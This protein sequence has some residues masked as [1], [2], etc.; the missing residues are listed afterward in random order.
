[1]TYQYYSK[2]FTG[3]LFIFSLF[4]VALISSGNLSAQVHMTNL[5]T[6]SFEMSLEMTPTSDGNYVTVG[7]VIR[8]AVTHAAIGIDIYLNKVDGAGGLIWSR[9]IAQFGT[10]GMGH[11]FPLSVTE[12]V[13][14]AGNAT[15]FA[16]TGMLAAVG[17]QEPVFIVT[18]DNNGNP[19][20]YNSYGGNLNGGTGLGTMAGFGAQI[21]QNNQ[22]QL[23][24]CGSM[25]I[26]DYVGQ[27]PFILVVQPD[28]TLDFL[29]L[30]HDVRYL[31]NQFGFDVRSHFADIEVVLEG[32]SDQTGASVPE[33][34]V[35]VGTTAEMNNPFSEI[36]VMRTDLA[37]GPVS[38]GLYGPENGNS[39]GTAIETTSNGNL[40]VA[41]I[42]VTPPP[43]TGGP[44]SP[45]ST[46]VLKL[47]SAMLG[48]LDQDRYYGF[49][50]LGDIRE[51]ANGDFLLSGRGVF[52]ADGAILRIKNDGTLVFGNGYG[53]PNVELFWDTHEMPSGD[54]Y[55]SGVTTTWCLGPADEYLTRA[56]SDGTVPFCNVYPLNID[57]ST[58]SDPRRETWLEI[59]NLDKVTEQGHE[60]IGP[61]TNVRR[62]CPNIIII[63]HPFPWDWFI[64]ADF[65]RDLSVDIGD[66]IATLSHQFSGGEASIPVEAADA[67]SDGVSDI[68]DAI[69][70]LA[71]LFNEGTTPSAPFGEPGPDPANEQGNIFVLE[72][73]PQS[74]AEFNLLMQLVELGL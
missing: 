32:T 64:R 24:V 29:R 71:Y 25:L 57:P 61:I 70:V 11:S 14:S 62:I 9:E 2:K 26:D 66:V 63:V 5:G 1:M 42:I 59:Q 34:Y 49:Q 69:F 20:R 55:A 4:T 15:G 30:Y 19:T 74:F 35:V 45:P 60:E 27:V 37:G 22:G 18:T 13:D 43:A 52:D 38:V 23:A 68:S 65:N 54:L 40:E 41:G 7:P 46:L 36:I 53:G 31:T 33:G 39:I 6:R 48:I 58:P 17:N 8:R 12:T 44:P 56:K 73:L 67:N 72:E 10:Q 50:T 21:I 51:A 28:L 3:L 16:I 47:E